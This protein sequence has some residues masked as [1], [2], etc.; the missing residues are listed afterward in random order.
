MGTTLLERPVVSTRINRGIKT[1][2]NHKWNRLD[3]TDSDRK[4]QKEKIIS[5]S[6]SSCTPGKK[7]VLSLLF[8]V[9]KE[10]NKIYRI[11]G[12]AS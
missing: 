1:S 8:F 3:Y 7:A 4:E 6:P 12:S 9:M 2:L 10:K 11:A 5:L